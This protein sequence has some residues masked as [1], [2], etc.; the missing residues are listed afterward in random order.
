[1]RIPD[2][3]YKK[4]AEQLKVDLDLVKKI[5]KYFW[6]ELKVNIRKGEHDAMY[7]R[8]LGTFFIG[9]TALRKA[10]VTTIK[11]IRRCLRNVNPKSEERL[12]REKERL[13]RL[14]RLRNTCAKANYKI[15]Q[16]KRKM[17]EQIS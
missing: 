11:D 16:S 14:L 2:Y 13:Q 7:V 5:N 1:M 4:T 6:N 17:N 15:K 10:I 12:I 3:F 9:R 8:G